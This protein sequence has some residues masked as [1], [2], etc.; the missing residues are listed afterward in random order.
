MPTR[1]LNRDFIKLEFRFSCTDKQKFRLSFVKRPNV[2]KKKKK[3]E[4]ID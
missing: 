2:I 1:F 3:L 4:N